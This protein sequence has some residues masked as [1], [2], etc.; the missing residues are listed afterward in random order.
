MNTSCLRLLLRTILTTLLFAFVGVRSG[1]WYYEVFIRSMPETVG[2]VRVGWSHANGLFLHSIVYLI[3]L[4]LL[5]YCLY[6]W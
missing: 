3:L 4:V 2:A 5:M 1:T 6:M